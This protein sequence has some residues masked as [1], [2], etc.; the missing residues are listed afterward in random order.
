M[1]TEQL[2]NFRRV[3]KIGISGGALALL[4]P[5]KIHE[6]ILNYNGFLEQVDEHTQ[7]LEINV[8]G[9]RKLLKRH[10]KQV[11][12]MFHPSKTP[13]LGFHKLVTKSSRQIVEITNMLGQIISWAAQ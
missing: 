7:Y 2:E 9:F 10:E 13:C 11:P 12:H 3:S 6:L 8:A 1:L 5:G 4:R